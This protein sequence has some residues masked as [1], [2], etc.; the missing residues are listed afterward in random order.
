MLQIKDIYKSFKDLDVLKGI[1]FE[2][3]KVRS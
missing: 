3:W 2:V 1:S